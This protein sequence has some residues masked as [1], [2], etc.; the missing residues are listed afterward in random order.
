MAVALSVAIP[1]CIPAYGWHTLPGTAP[2]E[3][4]FISP[5]ITYAPL[6]SAVGRMCASRPFR[7]PKSIRKSRS[8]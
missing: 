8:Y 4:A 6:A 2:R 1:P 7:E 5:V 3:D